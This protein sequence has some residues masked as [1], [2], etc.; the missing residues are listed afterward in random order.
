[1]KK[2]TEEKTE[3]KKYNEDGLLRTKEFGVCECP[4]VKEYYAIYDKCRK[5]YLGLMEKPN[6]KCAIRD[7]EIMTKDKNSLLNK[8][9][10]DF[11]LYKIGDLNEETGEFINNDISK[12]MSANEVEV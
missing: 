11:A 2:N 6:V 10:E 8:S 4:R 5:A 9:P 12:V 7:F 3:E 1:M